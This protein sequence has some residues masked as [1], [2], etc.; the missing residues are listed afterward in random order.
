M[1]FVFPQPDGMDFQP[2]AALVA[3]QLATYG[4]GPPQGNDWKTWASALF[5]VPALTSIPSPE[6]F[7]DWRLWADRFLDSVR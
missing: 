2:W 1:S 7:N 6:G 5:Y 4:V 3:E